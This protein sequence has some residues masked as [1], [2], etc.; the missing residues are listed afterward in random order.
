MLG[1]SP[2]N[3]GR[4]MVGNLLA[5]ALLL[6]VLANVAHVV[7]RVVALRR[8]AREVW[9]ARRDEGDPEIEGLDEAAFH[10]A[11]FRAY[12]PRG[13]LYA[14][15]GFLAA[16]AITLPAMLLLGAIWRVGWILG[17]EQ[18]QFAQGTLIWQFFMAFGLVA[19]WV[20]TAGVVM[21]R[22]HRDRPL[23]LPKEIARQRAR[24]TV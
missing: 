4:S 8:E 16:V 11:Y 3:P 10:R 5:F 21:S 22:H 1:A 23:A 6:A 12:G 20:L 19:C 9:A 13:T 24:K 15:A 7:H 18:A 17:G 14:Y 2:D